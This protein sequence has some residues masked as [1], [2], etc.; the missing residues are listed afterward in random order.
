MKILERESFLRD[1]KRWLDEAAAGQGRLAFVAGEAGIGKTVLVRVFVQSSEGLARVAVGGCDPL[2]TPRALGPLLDMAETLGGA[3]R[4]TIESGAV[5]ERLFRAVLAT[6]GDRGQPVVLVLEDVHWAD[7]A[8]LDLVR[9]LG[10]RITGARGMVVA[11]Y[12]EDEVGPR[13]PLTAV[14]G[15][16]ATSEGV[17]RM[18]LPPL[19]PGA[20]EV[21]ARGSALDAAELHR[22]TGGNPFFVTEC[23]AGGSSRAVPVTVRDAVLAR[24]SR[25]SEPAQRLLDAASVVG[26][27]AD[28]D[29]LQSAAG[30]DIAGIDEVLS[31]GIL[32]AGER[33]V[34]FRHEL[35]R[36][37]ILTAVPPQRAERLHRKVLDALLGRA[38]ADPA[39]LAHHA[40]AAADGSAVFTFALAAGKRAAA[41]GA[42]R[43]AAAQFARALRFADSLP[44]QE[45][46]A[47]LEALADQ[48]WLTDQL[49]QAIAADQ[50]AMRVWRTLGDRP[51]EAQAH[52][53]LAR[54]FVRNGRNA[55]A[56]QASLTALEILEPLGPSQALGAAY[57]TRAMLLMMDRQNVTAVNWGTRAI[58]LAEQFED[59]ETQ[60]LAHNFVGS[61]LILSGQASAGRRYLERSLA[62]AQEAD[63]PDLVAWTYWNLGSA[64]GEVFDFPTAEPA[65]IEGMAYCVEHDLDTAHAYMQAWQALVKLYQG[66]WTDAEPHARAVLA[67]P[68]TAATSRIM[69]LIALGRGLVRRG[70]PEGVKTLDGALAL[71]LPTGTLQRVAPIRAARA[72]AAWLAGNPSGTVEEARAAYELALGRAHPWFTGEL[73]YWLWRGG[74]LASPP[75]PCAEPFALQISGQWAAAADAWTRLS[76]PYEA[77]RALADAPDEGPLRKALEMFK[78]LGAR[79]MAT[80]VAR[81]LREAGVRNIPRGPRPAT[82]AHPAGLTS[83]EIEVVALLAEG[84]RNPEIARQLY[85]SAK[86]V[87]HHVSSILAKLGVRSRAEVVKEALRLGL[88]DAGV[89][90][91]ETL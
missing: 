70:D 26:A 41:L 72:E 79:P 18:T 7:G 49:D 60:I 86:T 13:H 2:S 90:P 37:A 65:L 71:A 80:I 67:R 12:R 91:I 55:D 48:C 87:D 8:T 69:A 1:L 34:S 38:D 77:A 74:A 42:H 52:L 78:Q 5:Q 83:R 66:R 53:R 32:R 58:A 76:C 85:V 89:R 68:Q 43:E 62:L 59:R 3:V 17:R 23:L 40:E 25:L 14:L 16:L 47:L 63:L 21:L 50:E 64:S 82:R 10:R 24:V 6:L 29:T 31:S 15:D 22:L 36:Q 11:T 33:A 75:E 20:V 39:R 88:L 61:A 27:E 51:R 44:P 73:A 56:E 30:E 19:T 57:R 81:R 46:A 84:L 9:F 45:R 4:R 35:A 54:T 28:L